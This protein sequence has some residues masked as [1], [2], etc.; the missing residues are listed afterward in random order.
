MNRQNVLVMIALGV[1]SAV[2]AVTVAKFTPEEQPVGSLSEPLPE[3]IVE[4]LNLDNVSE[5]DPEQVAQVVE[6]LIQI[7]DHEISERR[8]LEEQLSD[9]Q[10]E[11]TNLQQMLG[12]RVRSNSA[13][14]FKAGATER[15]AGRERLSED[16]RLAAAGF[17]PQ[18]IEDLR[19][20]ESGV[21]MRG[22]ALD[23]QARR[24]GWINSSRY[25]EER[26][27]LRDGGNSV[28][29]NLG[30]DA[31][32]R[33]LYASGRPNGIAVTNVISTSPAE[34]AGFQPG[35]II[36][37]YAGER[38][39]SARRLMQLRSEGESGAPVSVEV[40]RDGERLRLSIPRGP[41]GVES[42]P[43]MIDPDS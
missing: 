21:Q 20:Q 8:V 10:T 30:D 22:I 26:A 28:R 17:T 2:G 38:I 42:G 1:G 14:E 5:R 24:E 31:Y 9:L 43:R 18:Q 37:S 32:A 36:R 16:E 13:V 29:Q 6:S 4:Q 39:F 12:M 3:S 11:M 40:I 19:R 15:A 33:Y 35:D 23:D 34:L 7:L 25:F 41:M 27:S